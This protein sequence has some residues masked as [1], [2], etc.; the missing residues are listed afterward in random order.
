MS[1]A[2]SLTTF[3]L[4]ARFLR[5]GRDF[6]GWRLPSRDFVIC[7]NKRT[8]RARQL[9]IRKDFLRAT[10]QVVS[11]WNEYHSLYAFL[12]VKN[13]QDLKRKLNKNLVQNSLKCQLTANFLFSGILLRW[14][15]SHVVCSSFHS[16]HR[17]GISHNAVRKYVFLP[18]SRDWHELLATKRVWGTWM[19]RGFIGRIFS[20]DRGS[21]NLIFCITFSI[22]SNCKTIFRKRTIQYKY[23]LRNNT[24]SFSNNYVL[25]T[26]RYLYQWIRCVTNNWLCCVTYD[27]TYYVTLLKRFVFLRYL[28]LLMDTTYSKSY[29]VI[30]CCV[31]KTKK[32]ILPL[33]LQLFFFF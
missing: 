14:C 9:T 27:D 31:K 18:K 1:T 13:I 15:G 22:Y 23:N 6:F 12:L 17:R 20:F 4:S 28:T 32:H 24:Q 2:L 16:R 26:I 7:F 8:I 10:I 11:N 5:R 21:R 33:M 30:L 3:L 19:Y 29:T 25:M